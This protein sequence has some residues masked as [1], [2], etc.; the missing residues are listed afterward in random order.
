MDNDSDVVKKAKLAK[1]IILM[2]AGIIIFISLW[3]IYSKV[4]LEKKNCKNMN[5][6]YKDFPLI[7]SINIKNPTFSHSL[8]DYYVKTAYNCC[9][10]GEY[11]NDFVSTCALKDCIKQG[12]RCLDFE[13]YS[14]KNKP[15]IA[16]SS[17]NDYTVKETFNSI[18]FATAMDIINNYAF[19]GSTSPCPNDPLILHFRI[20]SK[21]KPIYDTMATDLYNTLSDRMLGNDYSYENHGKNIGQCKLQ[22]LMGKVVIIVD[23]TN[24]LFEKTPLDEYVNIASNSIFM[25]ALPY[26]DVKYTPDM[27]ELIE[28][29]KKNMTICLPNL[30]ASP[31]NPAP[32]V[33]M[34]YGCQF[35]GLSFQ[36]FDQ[37]ME[38][39]DL[40]FD[41]IGS[42]FALKPANLRFI[43][44]T[45]DKPAPPPENYAYNQRNVKT[46]Y[47]SFSI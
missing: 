36:N 27:D 5:S 28:F 10:A 26:D 6:L 43:P 44:V 34:S 33:A 16:V 47:Y 40:F 20:M 7:Q 46:D 9:C 2:M 22:K 32:A 14:V 41:G 38:Y 42:A 35:V 19:S 13:I 29:N 45:I 21:N 3:W 4:T 15:V 25:R 12:A 24:S 37:Y 31:D 8:R 1:M 23:K 18:P 17:I 39:Y 30:S 11:K